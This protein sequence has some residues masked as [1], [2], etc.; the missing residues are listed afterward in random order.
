MEM[1][2]NGLLRGPLQTSKERPEP[3]T[4]LKPVDSKEEKK[5]SILKTPSNKDI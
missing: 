3:L 4:A 2:G 5:K 1:T